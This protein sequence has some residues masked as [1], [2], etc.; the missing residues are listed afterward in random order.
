MVIKANGPSSV[1]PLNILS[2]HLPSIAQSFPQ[3]NS[4]DKIRNSYVHS[5]LRGLHLFQR[6][7]FRKGKALR[8][9]VVLYFSTMKGHQGWSFAL[10]HDCSTFPD[11][12]W[13]DT[14][15]NLPLVFIGFQTGL[16]GLKEST[17]KRKLAHAH[18]DDLIAVFR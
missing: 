7:H 18:L 16:P 9:G 4:H 8:K 12:A 17:F 13:L 11:Y 10:L 14:I 5:V 1:Q 15:I 2:V 3:M 6:G